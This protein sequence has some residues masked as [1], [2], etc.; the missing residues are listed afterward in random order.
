LFPD[1]RLKKAVF[2]TALVAASYLAAGLV[3]ASPVVQPRLPIPTPRG[4]VVVV[5]PADAPEA[6]PALPPATLDQAELE[7]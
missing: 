1:T 3:N 2:A 7:L 4:I 6:R 5:P